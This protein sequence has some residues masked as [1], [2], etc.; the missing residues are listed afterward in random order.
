MRSFLLPPVRH[1]LLAV[2]GSIALIACGGEKAALEDTPVVTLPGDTLT[3]AALRDILLQAPTAPGEDAS[4]GAVS[5]WTDLAVV[6][7]AVAGGATLDDDAT[8][9]SIMRPAIME[10]SIQRYGE[11]RAGSSAP[12][13]AQ[14]DSVT[15]GTNVRVFRS[16]KIGPIERTDTARIITEGRRLVALKQQATSLGGAA[17]AMQ[18]LGTGAAGIEVS[19]AQASTRQDLDEKL[20]ASIWRLN[21]NELSDPILGAGGIQVFERVPNTAAREQIVA[22]LGPVI[23]R[24]ADA[25]YI[26]SIMATRL[27]TVAGDGATRVREAAIEPG[28]FASDA[29][30]VTWANGDLTPSEARG[31]LAM[32]PAPER[33][34]MR[35]ASDTSLVQTLDRMA[36]REILFE[37]AASSGVD[38]IAVRDELLP[39]FRDQLRLLVADAQAAGDPTVWFRDLLSGRRQFVALPGTLPMVLRDRVEITVDEDA[40]VVAIEEA[41]RVWVAPGTAPTP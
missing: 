33:A 28:K 27:I 38:T 2:V 23:Q 24:R 29:N 5:I 9:N 6:T 32:M 35:L 8:L 34:R 17:A 14:I 12:T 1:H 21:D 40:R 36:R 20:A 3:A 26:D 18:A 15:R 19:P 30:L 22:W 39:L 37:L 11:S 16:Y 13:A 10:R 4:I 41:A 31:W 7:A 25:R